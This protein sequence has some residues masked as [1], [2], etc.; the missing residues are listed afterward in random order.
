MGL[1]LHGVSL[2]RGGA[3]Q[4]G[5]DH[6]DWNWLRDRGDRDVVD[7]LCDTD[8]ARVHT[9]DSQKEYLHRPADCAA[10]RAWMT[11]QRPW[12]SPRLLH[13]MDLL[14]ADPDYWRYCS[15]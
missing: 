2:S 13:R 15:W 8:G 11:S 5:A 7:D 10:C 6:P 12:S 14:E 3:C 4:D 1:H 9:T